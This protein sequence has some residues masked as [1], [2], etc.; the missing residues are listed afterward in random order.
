MIPHIDVA[1]R[2]RAAPD[3]GGA[4]PPPPGDGGPPV[5][6]G[7]WRGGGWPPRIAVGRVPR[8]RRWGSAS[9]QGGVAWGWLGGPDGGV[10][11]P[12]PRPGLEASSRGDRDL[13]ACWGPQIGVQVFRVII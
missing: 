10:R 11:A 1:W 6:G 7:G 12:R 13:V 3:R 4:G 9:R 2:R 8:L 5:A